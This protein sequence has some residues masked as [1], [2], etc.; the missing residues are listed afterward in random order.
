MCMA[1]VFPLASPRPLSSHDRSII[2][3]VQVE[4][5]HPGAFMWRQAPP[6]VWYSLPTGGRVD[7]HDTA[8]GTEPGV[9]SGY[10]FCYLSESLQS[11]NS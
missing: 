5:R 10:L 2:S 7:E 3:K 11:L 9:E 1:T 6:V 4:T 8:I